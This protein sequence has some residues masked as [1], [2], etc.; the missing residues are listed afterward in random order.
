MHGLDTHLPAPFLP[1]LIS[2]QIGTWRTNQPTLKNFKNETEISDNKRRI[3]IVVWDSG[4]EVR[5][6]IDHNG[7]YYWRGPR[8]E[9]QKE[10][11]NSQ[12]DRQAGCTTSYAWTNVQKMT[13]SMEVTIHCDTG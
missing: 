2:A 12:V 6:V 13:E 8:N 1:V 7:S 5:S 4:E 9:V 11:E 10:A 3:L